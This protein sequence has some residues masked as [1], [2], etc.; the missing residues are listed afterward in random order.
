MKGGQGALVRGSQQVNTSLGATPLSE[1]EQMAHRRRPRRRPAPP[2]GVVR[3][4]CPEKEM[5]RSCLPS[6]LP[7]GYLTPAPLPGQHPRSSKKRPD[8]GGG[9][10]LAQEGRA[11][12]PTAD[13]E[14]RRGVTCPGSYGKTELGLNAGPGCSQSWVPRALLLPFHSRAGCRQFPF[15]LGKGPLRDKYHPCPSPP[16]F[17]APHTLSLFVVIVLNIYLF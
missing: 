5:P 9:F 16:L 10:P 11:P 14:P 7:Q 4:G 15:P 1:P 8:S 13:K 12:Q 3:E 6:L 17:V 2:P